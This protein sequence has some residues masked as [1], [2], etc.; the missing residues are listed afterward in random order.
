MSTSS[1]TGRTPKRKATTVLT[2][3][4]LIQRTTQIRR[5]DV[6]RICCELCIW[7]AECVSLVR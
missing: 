2:E 1:A 5:R 3:E 4:V 7:G 6:V